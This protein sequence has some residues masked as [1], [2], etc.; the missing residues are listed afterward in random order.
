MKR[1]LSLILCA[2][3]LLSLFT[4]NSHAEG[5]KIVI[6]EFNYP[7]ISYPTFAETGIPYNEIIK[8]F[9]EKIEIKYENGAMYVKDL[10]GDT[11]YFRDELNGE[12]HEGVLVDGYWR[13]DV[14]KE[15]YDLGGSMSMYTDF[16]SWHATYDVKTGKR[17]VV[18]VNKQGTTRYARIFSMYP[19][20]GYGK[21]F[22]SVIYDLRPDIRVTDSYKNG[23][24]VTQD[25]SKQNN[26]SS[27]Y[28][29]YDNKGNLE[30]LNVSV[31]ETDEYASYIQ[32]KGWSDDTNEYVPVKAPKG[33][34]NMSLEE[35]MALVPT[36]IKC[37]HQWSEVLCDAPSICALCKREK[38]VP[39][40]HKWVNNGAEY[41]TCT[42]C[43]GIRYLFNEV[44][45]PSYLKKP[46]YKLSDTGINIED[47]TSGL[48]KSITVKY[49]DGFIKVPD[50]KDCY[51]DI[52]LKGSIDFNDDYLT[53]NGWNI[54]EVSED[55]LDK[56]ELE[57][58][59]DIAGEEPVSNTFTYDANGALT[60]FTIYSPD[61]S[62]GYDMVNDTVKVGYFVE[63]EKVNYT[64]VYQGGI[65]QKRQI[66]DMKEG[67]RVY[68]DS[69]LKIEKV[70]IFSMGEYIRFVPDKGWELDVDNG[71]AVPTPEGFEGKDAKYFSEK[72]PHGVDFCIHS[73]EKTDAEYIKKCS[74]CGETVVEAT[75]TPLPEENNGT[76]N[77]SV[78]VII[79]IG[80]LV[81]AVAITAVIIIIK[82]KKGKE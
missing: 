16:H 10:G 73:F 57:F 31:Y 61:G 43:N 45:M 23:V 63:E 70:Q 33:Y 37:E 59:K 47:I 32:G 49:E 82:K 19:E 9:P 22:L 18:S 17:G 53:Q 67:T 35:L 26:V 62:I 75:P 29:R 27:V 77:S 72:Y 34:E 1:F 64:D 74:K 42:T 60:Y 54:I 20:E 30:W 28:A 7:A 41:D 50:A 65:F 66:Y 71:E 3:L 21:D 81:L 76:G 5:E 8:K 39:F 56:V 44:K 24:L 68:Y 6:P 79:I 12:G 80:A 25:V 78:T 38:G 52:D 55:K 14:S 48:M 46:V 51:F 58:S 4:F 2:V 13:F 40:G 11:A 36:D 15:A 69:D